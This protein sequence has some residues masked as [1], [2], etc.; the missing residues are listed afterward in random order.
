LTTFMGL[1]SCHIFAVQVAD[2]LGDAN[3]LTIFVQSLAQLCLRMKWSGI[4]GET[5]AIQ[6]YELPPGPLRQIMRKLLAKAPLCALLATVPPIVH[7]A[8]VAAALTEADGGSALLIPYRV[9]RSHQ[10][11]MSAAV[12]PAAYAALFADLPGLQNLVSVDFSRILFGASGFVAAVQALTTQTQLTS[13]SLAHCASGHSGARVLAGALPRWRALRALDVSANG[14]QTGK[15]DSQV[16]STDALAAATRQLTELSRLALRAVAYTSALDSA[17][18]A[19]QDLDLSQAVLQQPIE[20]DSRIVQ[21]SYT[22][23]P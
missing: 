17:L 20:A 16:A 11:D 13:V 9:T 2:Y 8:L 10:A 3:D 12:A 23:L 19:L 18:Q 1:H 7:E 21:C 6:L 15:V 22:R 14:W 5:R 4:A